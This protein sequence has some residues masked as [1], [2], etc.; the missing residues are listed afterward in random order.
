MAATLRAGEAASTAARWA[1]VQARSARK[2]EEGGAAMEPPASGRPANQGTAAV[3]GAGSGRRWGRRR[4]TQG[5]AGGWRR[6]RC[7]GSRRL[8]GGRGGQLAAAAGRRRL[9]GIGQRRLK[10]NCD[11]ALYHVGN[12]NL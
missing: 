4:L 9:Q 8:G 1:V 3:G 11:V 2:G 5:R 10:K 12:P 6:G 7:E